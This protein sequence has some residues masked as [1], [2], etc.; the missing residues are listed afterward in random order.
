M[1]VLG[2]LLLIDACGAEIGVRFCVDATGPVDVG[3]SLGGSSCFL[4]SGHSV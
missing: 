2:G 3:G 1:S 4:I